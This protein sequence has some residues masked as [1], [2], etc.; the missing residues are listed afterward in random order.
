MSAA[1]APLGDWR[2]PTPATR[3]TRKS[4]RWSAADLQS[5]EKWY[6]NPK[7]SVEE[8][9]RRLNREIHSVE[10]QAHRRGLRRA[11]NWTDEAIEQ[12]KADWLNQA[13]TVQEVA[14]KHDRTLAACMQKASVLGLRRTQRAKVVAYAR[15]PGPPPADGPARAEAERQAENIRAYYARQCQSVTVEVVY[16]PG[17]MTRV[18]CWSPRIVEPV[19]AR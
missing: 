2:D 10:N 11:V 6:P 1:R 13:M 15:P 4:P 12:F 8:I 16:V 17:T 7:I 9:A 3:K 19:K 18:G 14:D 5:L